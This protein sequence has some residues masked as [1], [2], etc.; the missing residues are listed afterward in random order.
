MLFRRR[1]HR[2]GARKAPLS[3]PATSLSYLLSSASD[4]NIARLWIAMDDRDQLANWRYNRP[5]SSEHVD[6]PP[7]VM[8]PERNLISTDNQHH[9]DHHL[10]HRGV[11]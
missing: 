5:T 2:I 8:L 9:G 11:A 4:F 10:P 3:S 7:T 6:K 1:E